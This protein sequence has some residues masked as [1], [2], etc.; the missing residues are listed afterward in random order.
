MITSE[1]AREPKRKLSGR[2]VLGAMLAFFAVIVTADAIMIYQAVSTF[3]GVDNT[4]AY[5]DGLA[6]NARIAREERQAGLGWKETVELRADPERVRVELKDATGSPVDGIKVAVLL[7]R[8]VTSA[9]DSVVQLPQMS[10]GVFEAPVTNVQS[11]GTWIA[12][13]RAYRTGGDEAEPIFETR[14]RLWV[15]P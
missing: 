3:G 10:P 14:R 4:N 13:V 5:R 11:P 9:A 7:G 12:T 1:A 6:Y 8:A 2:H 15:A